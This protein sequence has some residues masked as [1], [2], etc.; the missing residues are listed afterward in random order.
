MSKMN[1][2]LLQERIKVLYEIISSTSE[3]YFDNN[4]NE[5]QRGLYETIIGAAIWYLPSGNELFS[6]KISTAALDKI[7]AAPHSTKLVEEHSFPRKV[8]GKYLYELYKKSKG[9]LTVEDIVAVYKTKLGKYNLVL[10]E[11]NDRLKKWQKIQNFK[12]NADNFL[13]VISGI[14]E[15]AYD[16]SNIQLTAFSLEQYV[17]Y[18]KIQVRGLMRMNGDNIRMAN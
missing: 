7:K 8:G 4:L 1:V 16:K 18:K 6:G 11:E 12:H 10:K 14:E 15:Y 3:Q 2:N 9:T 5:G 17:A 13:E